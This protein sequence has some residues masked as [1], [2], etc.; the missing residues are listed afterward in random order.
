MG[1][2]F[3]LSALIFPGISDTLGCKYKQLGFQNALDLNCLH[4]SNKFLI[5]C[6]GRSAISCCSIYMA[7]LSEYREW[8]SVESA[9]LYPRKG[10]WGMNA[11]H[12]HLLRLK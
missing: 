2:H 3:N 6:F 11:E 10:H 1:G 7:S 4:N 8:G 5:N 9:A 12:R